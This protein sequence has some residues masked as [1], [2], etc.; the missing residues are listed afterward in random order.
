[1]NKMRFERRRALITGGSSGIGLE[2]ACQLAA[3]GADVAV[4]ARTQKRL[5]AA[6]AQI[7]AHARPGGRVLTRALDITD[8]DAVNQTCRE[9][10]DR[11]GRIDLLVCNAGA[12]HAA[13]A[14]NTPYQVYRSLM[15]V[16][17][18]GTVNTIQSLLDVFMGQGHGQIVAV[19]S[20]AGFLGVYGYTA[21]APTKFAL[22]GYMDC[23]RQELHPHGVSV[24][25][26]YPGNTDTPQLAA[27]NQTRPE[28]T[29]IVQ[30]KGKVMSAK[31]VAKQAINGIA[32]GRATILPG[33]EGKLLH[34]ANRLVPEL[35]RRGIQRSLARSKPDE[36]ALVPASSKNRS[37]PMEQPNE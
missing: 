34:W 9:L 20:I 27:E 5:D 30:G 7:E 15:E 11:L 33:V 25:V 26:V 17:Y 1:M 18:F 14:H 10:A 23:L 6:E 16:N 13:A 12:A 8:R 2:L 3:E 29:R 32:L 31:A 36:L 19:A 24:S 35:M 37:Q 4:V 22:A 21:Y 28:G